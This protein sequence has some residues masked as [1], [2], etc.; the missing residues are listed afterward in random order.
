MNRILDTIRRRLR[1]SAV[2]FFIFSFHFSTFNFF[3]QTFPVTVQTILTPPYSLRLSDYSQPGMQRIMVHLFVND[4]N[5]N[6][7]PV[8]LHIK[9]EAPGVTIETIPNIAV[10]PFFIT[11]G[12]VHIFTGAD[13]TAYFSPNN[14]NFRGFSRDAYQRAGQLPD[15]FWRITVQV[16]DI[17]TGRTISNAGAMSAWMATGKPPQLNSPQNNAEMG[18]ITGAPLTFSWLPTNTGVPMQG[19]S[20]QYAL[21][22]WELRMPGV[23]PYVVANHFPPFY[24][25]NPTNATS[26]VLQAAAL[27][28]EPGMKYAWRVT[29]SDPAG[30]IPFEQDG[31]SEVRVFAFQNRCDGVTNFTA[32]TRLQSAIFEWQ[33]APNHTSFNVEAE[34]IYSEWRNSSYTYNNR[35]TW[36]N[37]EHGSGYRVR[38]HPVCNNGISTGEWSEWEKMYS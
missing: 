14:L 30:R 4:L 20:V 24:T 26:L 10:T 15:G 33:P 22:I 32:T 13:L 27:M 38:V 31:H 18:L 29:A 1:V 8:R 2:F 17:A 28:L 37:F 11:G 19:G 12:A 25:S 3:A 36:N 16:V 5:V 21:N 23:D 9:M 6:N 34:N 35:I 7:R